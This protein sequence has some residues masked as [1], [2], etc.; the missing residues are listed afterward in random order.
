[1]EAVLSTCVSVS[2]MCS[3]SVVGRS[4]R[5]GALH[6]LDDDWSEISVLVL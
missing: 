3:N 5:C 4:L 2:K 1:M 6:S